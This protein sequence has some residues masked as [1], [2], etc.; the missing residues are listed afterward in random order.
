MKNLVRAKVQHNRLQEWLDWGKESL[1]LRAGEKNIALLLRFDKQP[2]I[3]YIYAFSP[4]YASRVSWEDKP[5]FAGV[6]A[7]GKGLFLAEKALDVFWDQW[8]T[9]LTDDHAFMSDEIS[10]EINGY[11]ESIVQN[12]R[13]NL[14][15]TELASQM[16]THNYQHYLEYGAVQD[17]I[18]LLLKGKNP[19]TQFRSD[20]AMG[21]CLD[22]PGFLAY[23]SDAERY[24]QSQGRKYLADHQE[25]FLLQFLEKDALSTAYQQLINDASHPAHKMKAITDAV[26]GSGAKTVNVT[27]HKDG[28]TLTFK[29]A[30]N[31][32]RGYKNYYNTYDIPAHDRREF[33]RMFGAYADYNAEDITKI[34]YGRNT[35]YEAVPAQEESM[36]DDMGMGGMTM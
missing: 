4:L 12:D 6:Y 21:R 14:S 20:Y 28:Q 32:L 22:E 33:E 34:T 25:K 24:V 17:A 2:G 29:A 5:Q 13:G 15:V 9:P 19:D 16:L 26:S 36:S 10:K 23:L 1:M 8:A 31:S 30:A 3:S 27:V 7:S 11:I 35:I 18:D